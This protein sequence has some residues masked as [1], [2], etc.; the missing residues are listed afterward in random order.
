MFL[1]FLYYFKRLQACLWKNSGNSRTGYLLKRKEDPPIINYLIKLEEVS[2][3]KEGKEA[4]DTSIVYPKANI[5]NRVIAKFIDLLIAAAFY[6]VLS[7]VG[8][9]AGITYLLTADGFSKGRSIGKRLIGLKVIVPTVNQACSF[10]ESIIRNFPLAICYLLFFIPY[11]RWIFM[12][13]ILG[14]EGLLIVGNERGLRIGDEL[15]KT[16][17]LDGEGF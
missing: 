8:F 9:Y 4:D 5:L 12:F 10:K 2:L 1:G 7:P 15:A 3:F 13:L 17:V 11:V 6:K 16:Q 14:I